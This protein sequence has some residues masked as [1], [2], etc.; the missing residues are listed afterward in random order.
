[1]YFKTIQWASLLFI[2]FLSACSL[3]SPAKEVNP[4]EVLPG[5]WEIQQAFRN[6]S[7]TKT[8]ESGYF[9]FTAT[10]MTTNILGQPVSAAYTLEDKMIKHTGQ[11]PIDYTIGDLDS[12][13]MTL[14]MKYEGMDF[15]FRVKKTQ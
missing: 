8:L 3:D 2:T 10:N 9:D 15:V 5:K 4:S 12:T 1:M 7:P 11:P 14:S 13:E 6:G